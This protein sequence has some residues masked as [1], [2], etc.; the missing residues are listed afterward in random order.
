MLKKLM[1][2]EWKGTFKI[3][4]ILLAVVAGA[5]LV[6]ALGWSVMIRYLSRGSAEYHNG[7][8]MA[9]VAVTMMGMGTFFAYILTMAGVTYLL[10]G[11][12]GVHF[13]KT[14]YTDEGYLTHTLP[15][16]P[17]QILFSKVFVAGCWNLIILGA[18][19][20][21]IVVLVL[22]IFGSFSSAYNGLYNPWAEMSRDFA[23][24]WRELNDMGLKVEIV[25]TI[26]STILAYIISPFCG[27]IMLFGSLTIGQL[28][29]KHKLLVG[30][31]T[32]VGVLFA[33]SILG[34]IFRFLFTLPY[35]VR[36][37]TS[38]SSNVAAR[39]VAGNM[40]GTLDASIALSLVTGAIMYFVMI[41]IL[42]KKLN[43][44]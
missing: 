44:D 26:V 17:K 3:C 27:V 15:A 5:T 8:E 16:T 37:S 36:V 28:A 23:Q 10:I 21:S 41:Q 43:L 12:L 30:I 35:L 39:S 33:N 31:L 40:S 1:K 18:M 22:T 32:Y 38:S 42:S 14:M 25:H 20:I 7:N 29:S 34:Q 24:M 9:S 19:G 13:Y 4:L 6:G 11:Y 2:Y